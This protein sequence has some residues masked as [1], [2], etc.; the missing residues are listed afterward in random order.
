MSFLSMLN[1]KIERL[2]S[3]IALTQ[4]EIDAIKE[5]GWVSNYKEQIESRMNK[6]IYKEGSNPQRISMKEHL[7]ALLM[8]AETNP[9]TLKEEKELQLSQKK[10]T[11]EASLER[12]ETQLANL[13]QSE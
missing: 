2:E 11:L 10:E 1:R 9:E 12:A 8:E 3:H 7:Y 13:E 5:E 4:N 6:L